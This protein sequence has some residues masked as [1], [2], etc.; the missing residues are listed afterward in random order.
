MAMNPDQLA[1]SK[2]S[3]LKHFRASEAKFLDECKSRRRTNFMKASHQAFLKRKNA[4]LQ[5][6]KNQK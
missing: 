5:H 2:K 1:K 6:P 3:L 4:L